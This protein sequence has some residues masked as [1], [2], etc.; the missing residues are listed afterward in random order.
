MDAHALLTSQG[1]RG[2]GHSLHKTDDTIGLAKPILVSRKNNVLGVGRKSHVTS[3]QWWLNAL[4]EQLKSLD[5]SGKTSIVQTKTNTKLGGLLA[6]STAGAA[7]KYAGANGLYACFVSGGLL[8][9]TIRSGQEEDEETGES[10]DATPEV[11]PMPV[12]KETKEERRARKEARRKRKAAK[13]ARRNAEAAEAL[14]SATKE[15]KRSKDNEKSIAP[16]S[17][18]ERQAR[19]EARRKRREEKDKRRRGEGG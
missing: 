8:Q 13:A 19:K 6:S 14:R 16:E 11:E 15:P 1:W 7:G 12:R 4:D 10:T 18:E 17:K 5:T 2:S 9:G 3:D